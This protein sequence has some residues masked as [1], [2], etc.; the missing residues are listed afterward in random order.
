MPVSTAPNPVLLTPNASASSSPFSQLK[1]LFSGK[2][3]QNETLKPVAAN[4]PISTIAKR[5]SS[6]S[7]LR[8]VWS[9]KVVDGKPEALKILPFGPMN[10]VGKGIRERRPSALATQRV[11]TASP[12][13]ESIDS[14]SSLDLDQGA[15]ETAKLK[16]KRDSGVFDLDHIMYNQHHP[17]QAVA[18]VAFLAPKSEPQ[19]DIV[20]NSVVAPEAPVKLSESEILALTKAFSLLLHPP[21][22]H[23][24]NKRHSRHY[25]KKQSSHHSGPLPGEDFTQFVRELMFFTMCLFVLNF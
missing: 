1:A 12:P 21:P 25:A 4:K 17:A 6:F 22:N 20:D 2:Q 10:L 9:S 24:P 7:E 15:T 8:A 23:L 5:S 11:I 13:M 18:S 16:D 14:R 19:P 3:Q